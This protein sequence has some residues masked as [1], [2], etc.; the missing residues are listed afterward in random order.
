M[1]D[2]TERRVRVCAHRLRVAERA[3]DG[4]AS[5]KNQRATGSLVEAIVIVAIARSSSDTGETS[6]CCEAVMLRGRLRACG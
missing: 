5:R 2:M 1:K 4:A 3:G 6:T